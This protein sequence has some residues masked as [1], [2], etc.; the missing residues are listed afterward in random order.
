MNENFY[1][2]AW[3]TFSESEISYLLPNP[4]V[5]KGLRGPGGP[6][7]GGSSGS[8]KGIGLQQRCVSVPKTN[9]SQLE[10]HRKKIASNLIFINY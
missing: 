2:P 1:D 4:A 6:N 3:M 7:S 5:P 8:S 10:I 9:N